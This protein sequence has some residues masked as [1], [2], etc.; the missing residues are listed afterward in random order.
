MK[1]EEYRVELFA[2]LVLYCSRW[3]SPTATGIM[4]LLKTYE[5]VNAI[6]NEGLSLQKSDREHEKRVDLGG[7][8]H[9]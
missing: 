8:L 1:V 7:S 3:A 6:S 2:I 5:Q 9:L 4:T